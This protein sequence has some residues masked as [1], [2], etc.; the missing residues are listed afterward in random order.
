M[1][2]TDL[3]KD[4][5]QLLFSL[6]EGIEIRYEFKKSIS[7]HFI[8]VK[9]L[10]LFNSNDLYIEKEIELEDKFSKLFPNEDLVF[11]SQDSLSKID[12]PDLILPYKISYRQELESFTFDLTKCLEMEVYGENNYA[13]AA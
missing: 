3:I 8:E 1:N 10:D 7:T 2:S 4:E 12:N 6:I 9:P 11:I 13:L 5:L